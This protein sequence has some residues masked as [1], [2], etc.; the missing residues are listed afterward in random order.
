MFDRELNE[1]LCT[2]N[3]NM[4]LHLKKNIKDLTI[5]IHMM[6]TNVDRDL[7]ESEVDL[8]HQLSQP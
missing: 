2:M 8:P 4:Y 6:N 3:L 1:G 5:L 7:K